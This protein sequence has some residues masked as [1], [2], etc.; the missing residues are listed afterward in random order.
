MNG[1]KILLVFLD[2]FVRLQKLYDC[3][4]LTKIIEYETVSIFPN[5]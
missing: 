4:I 1:W 2:F 3:L 5:W